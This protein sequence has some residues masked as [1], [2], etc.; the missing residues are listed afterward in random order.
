MY[1]I[2]KGKVHLIYSPFFINIKTMLQGSSIGEIDLFDHTA[3]NMSAVAEDGVV[4]CLVLKISSLTLLESI[5]PEA[6]Y[7]LKKIAKE[8]KERYKHSIDDV[9]KFIEKVTQKRNN[10]GGPASYDGLK[11]S[12]LQLL[13]K[14]LGSDDEE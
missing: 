3:R 2:S 13:N 10:E 1:F 14:K 6:I 7:Q 8:K 9:N 11:S 4:E 5:I 12:I